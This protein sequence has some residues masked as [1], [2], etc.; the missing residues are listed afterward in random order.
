[1]PGWDGRCR[2]GLRRI[3]PTLCTQLPS[4][5]PRRPW[6][7]R[8]EGPA[9]CTPQPPGAGWRRS[10]PCSRAPR[11][12]RAW[13][14]E[15][16]LARLD[17][18]CCFARHSYLHRPHR[19]TLFSPDKARGSVSG[20]ETI[21]CHHILNHRPSRRPSRRRRPFSTGTAPGLAACALLRAPPRPLTG[22]SGTQF[23][24][25]PCGRRSQ[26]H[27]THCTHCTPSVQWVVHVR[28]DRHLSRRASGR[29]E[30]IA[31]HPERGI[32]REQRKLPSPSTGAQVTRQPAGGW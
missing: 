13:T 23:S 24:A 31:R 14:L 12:A 4:S 5:A 17:F 22:T 7:T 26:D 20:S 21:P 18:G 25:P 19:D 30:E 16:A 11:V 8:R 9:S 10:R 28:W 6:C 29:S 1:M 2:S 3:D 15:A 27:R 32:E